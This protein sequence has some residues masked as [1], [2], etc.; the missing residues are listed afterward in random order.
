[1]H[2]I[3]I[4]YDDPTFEARAPEALVRARLEAIVAELT[5]EDVEF[6]CTFVTDE[7]I[8]EL[9][10]QWRNKDEA[11]DILSFVLS[12]MAEDCGDIDWPEGFESGSGDAEE[13]GEGLDADQ[14]RIL[15]D[16]VV[17]LDSLKRNADYFSVS[18]DEELYRL[19]IHGVLHL[20]G[21]NHA[22][23]D[24]SEPM[25]KRQEHLLKQ[26]RG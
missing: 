3:D 10:L 12:D 22:T 24:P 21:E 7:R 8:K 1:M 15:G 14:P 5:Q 13:G 26:L 2:I 6:S 16:M 17:S 4:E 19:L 18:E 23:N 25:L 20:L 9:N 11:T